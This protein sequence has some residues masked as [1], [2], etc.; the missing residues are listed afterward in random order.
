MPIN[1]PIIGNDQAENSWKLE[2]TNQINNEEVRVNALTS[3]INNIESG[4]SVPSE[5]TIDFSLGI[6]TGINTTEGI[7]Y[8]V[9]VNCVLTGYAVNLNGPRPSFSPSGSL[10]FEVRRNDTVDARIPTVTYTSSTP[11]DFTQGR[12]GLS[13]TFNQF[14]SIGLTAQHANLTNGASL[15]PTVTFIFRR[16]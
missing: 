14:S 13:E 10:R 1:Q 2:A 7:N 5:F 3:R 12:T 9:P 6:L 16:T 11:Q 8:P 15:I 4:V